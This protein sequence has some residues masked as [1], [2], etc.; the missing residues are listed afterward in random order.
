MQFQ[1][2]M[3]PSVNTYYRS[4]S[5]GQL[6]GCVLISD[7]GRKYIKA[8]KDAVLVQRV[9]R[10]DGRL[11]LSVKLHFNDNRRADIDNRVKALADALQKAGVYE[12]DSQ[13]DILHVERGEVIKGGLCFVELIAIV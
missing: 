5:K 9:K 6:A 2:P 4:V 13:I 10:I 11:K 8:V 12:D 7:D 1:L 3:P